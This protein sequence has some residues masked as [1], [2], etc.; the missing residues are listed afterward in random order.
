[1]A[2]IFLS[3]RSERRRAAAHFAKI[4]ECFGYTV[5]HDYHLLDASAFAEETS[6]HIR[7]AK[8][9]VVMWCRLSAQS[10]WVMREAAMAA[11]LGILVPVQIEP[12]QLNLDFASSYID[13]SLWNGAPFDREL[14]PLLDSITLRVGRGPQ[15]DYAAIRTFDE[16]WYQGGALSMTE[17]PLGRSAQ[18]EEE[19]LLLTTPLDQTTLDA[20]ASEVHLVQSERAKAEEM[21]KRTIED[22]RQRPGAESAQ[23]QE[24]IDRQAEVVKLAE[25][26]V[27]SLWGE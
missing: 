24:S 10:D 14:F 2:E 11:K 6:Q 16:E 8:A 23:S 21:A 12:C 5:W 15:L 18:P 26:L 4:L 19:P 27:N 3:Y 9:V 7:E 13:L 22:A 17:F 25:Q 20:V 1:M